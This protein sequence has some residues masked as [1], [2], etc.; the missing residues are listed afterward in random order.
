MKKNYF[1]VLLFVFSLFNAQNITFYDQN[2]KNK[3]LSSNTGNQ[4]AKN[5]SGNYFAVDS[6][7][8]GEISQ[9]EANMVSYL[10]ISNSSIS[11]L[12]SIG[13]F[14]NLTTLKCQFNTISGILDLTSITGLQT[15]ECQNNQLTTLKLTNPIYINAENNN[16]NNLN[17]TNYSVLSYLNIKNNLF[18]NFTINH[19]QLVDFL[20]D[21]NPLSQL[22]I[23]DVSNNFT[24][25]PITALQTLY[26]NAY[27]FTP[28]TF[29]VQNF[30]NLTTINASINPVNGLVLE[31]L[32]SLNYASI[33]APIKVTVKNIN[34]TII[35]SGLS[36]MV[37]EFHLEGV[38]NTATINLIAVRAKQYYFKNLTSV[39]NLEFNIDEDA[40]LINFD[41]LPVLTDLKIGGYYSSTNTCLA[42]DFS[43]LSALKNLDV[44]EINYS[45]M[46]LSNLN[47]LKKIRIYA[48][49]CTPS[50]SALSI[51]NLAQ[52]EEIIIG[53][54]KL[55]NLSM[56]GL[57]SLK[58]IKLYNNGSSSLSMNTLPLLETFYLSSDNGASGNL[59]SNLGFN[60][61]PTL[62]NI[63]LVHPFISAIT[64]NNLH[65]LKTFKTDN[66]NSSAS[67]AVAIAYDFSNLP[68]LNN[69]ILNNTKVSTFTLSNLPSLKDL[70]FK[71]SYI[72]SSYTFQNLPAL[73]NL[74]IEGG[75]SD[76]SQSSPSLYINDVSFNNLPVIK[77][78]TLKDF[79]YLNSIN[80]GNVNTSLE[81]FHLSNAVAVYGTLTSLAFNN[82][83]QL[84]TLLVSRALTSLPLSNLPQ[85]T[86][87]NISSNKFTTFT[88]ENLPA[89]QNFTSNYNNGPG[90]TYTLNMLNLPVLKIANVS[91]NNG[92]L[93]RID[94]SQAPQLE[95]LHFIAN[96]YGSAQTLDYINLKNGNPNLLV[97]NTEY[98]KNI[99]VD[100]DNERILLQS[101]DPS[102]T[103]T[104]F[105][106][107]CS[108]FPAGSNY[109]VI[110]NSKYDITN[111]GCDT[112]DPQF[113][114]LKIGINSGSINSS[115]IANQQGQHA[116]N[117]QAGS[118]TITPILE[119]PSYFNISPTSFT[120]NFPAQTSPLTQNFCLTANGTHNDL[121]V[122]ILP[123]TAASPGFDAKYKIVYKNKGTTTQSGTLVFNYDDNLMNF[124]NATLSPNSQ[125]TG[126]LNWNFTNLLPFEAREITVILKLNT[127]TQTPAL[128]GGDILHYTSQINGTTD[129]TPSDNIFT[130]NQ[131]V[132]NS[133]DP[134]DKTCLEGTAIT[135]AKVGDYVHYLIRFE[136]TGTANAQNI[137]VKDEIDISKYDVSSLIALNASHN[138]AT[139]I[140]GNVVEFIF[141]NIQLPFN[142]A[143]NDGYVS[144]KIKTRSNL[145]L[146][147]SFSNSAKIYF[148][149]NHPIITNTYTTTVQNVLGTSEISNDKPELSIYPN[150]VKDVLNIQSKN[151]IVKAEIYDVNGRILIST[152]LKG[153]SIH[154]SELSKGHYIIKLFSKDKTT[155]HKFIKN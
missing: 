27:S 121:E 122:V 67:N 61:L 98:I 59:I 105:T 28:P 31:N 130:L 34:P 50:S 12:V 93:K 141:E 25:Q 92:K 44:D 17:L 102:L 88:V 15:V 66:P 133:F 155:V 123:I 48:K 21:G 62:Q 104:I 38:S 41:N 134:N 152:S 91:Y 146:G 54:N 139:R 57:N 19:P 46:N 82:F 80:F 65:N 2:L 43:G 151:Q 128:N 40:T 116:V 95:Q 90:N 55:K 81:N 37:N 150:P 96:N 35:S 125:T 126:V 107:Y 106:P 45:S 49:S 6:N 79:F 69:I 5:I 113:S 8:D 58:S 154:V 149:Y 142:N 9:T 22:G 85:L 129:E 1:F 153:N 4:I 111:N 51:S 84:K 47:Q 10:D 101:L 108:M 11:N 117:L 63:E 29:A 68:L 16:M 75:Q 109:T 76:S 18:T 24:L 110:G 83:P 119:N 71:K 103:N 60:N 138:F 72:G 36:F 77:S 42:L 100:D 145:T 7:Q 89:L 56:N 53:D 86:T 30:P 136:N 52:L 73:E 120:A 14:S 132:V 78:I 87:L 143:T 144:F 112:S 124:L 135:Q 74:T 70:S 32:P 118:H 97:L 3:I 26:L 64:F 94:L 127:P 140:T 137:V 20:A 23:N 131:T 115:Y 114:N 13:Y 39:T 148:D 147:D 99:C 33:N